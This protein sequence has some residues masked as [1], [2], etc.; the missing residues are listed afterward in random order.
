MY[1]KNKKIIVNF[2]RV[3]IE[4]SNNN[5]GF[6]KNQG[7]ANVHTKAGDTIEVD[8]IVLGRCAV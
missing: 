1:K 5:G 8:D 3:S 6:T 7:A 2:C 4:E